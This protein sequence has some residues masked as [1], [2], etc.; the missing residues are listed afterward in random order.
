MSNMPSMEH[1]MLKLT[2]SELAEAL[3]ADL[4]LPHALVPWT[5]TLYGVVPTPAW[6]RAVATL[7]ATPR[8]GLLVFR[9]EPDALG[10]PE[11][12]FAQRAL[13]AALGAPAVQEAHT[14]R[15]T[16]GLAVVFTL[17]PVRSRPAVGELAPVEGADLLALRPDAVSQ[18]APLVRPASLSS[19]DEDLTPNERLLIAAG[20]ATLYESEVVPTVAGLVAFGVDPASFLGGLHAII[21][22]RRVYRAAGEPVTLARSIVR[23]LG[24]LDPAAEAVRSFVLHAMIA[25]SWVPHLDDEPLQVLMSGQRLEVRWTACRVERGPAN[26]TLSRHLR[27]RRLLSPLV[28][29]PAQLGRWLMAR[30]GSRVVLTDDGDERVARVRLPMTRGIPAEP[31]SEPVPEPI[32]ELPAT[33]PHV[34]ADTRDAALLSLFDRHEQLSA[35]H[36]MEELGWSRSTTRDVLAR[37]VASGRL[38]G[39]ASSARSPHQTYVRR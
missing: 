15:C 18:L 36:V 11:S 30:G 7:S 24:L 32:V 39:T 17:A 12:A 8:G 29:D 26:P 16:D 1:V 13:L 19:I 3:S 38:A 9:V 31:A 28:E 14:Q 6:K 2:V 10:L 35:R 33:V 20:A 25:R 5:R 27:A 34:A 21:E 37:L 4:G 23:E 22:S